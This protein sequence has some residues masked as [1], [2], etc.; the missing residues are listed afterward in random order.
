MR[1]IIVRDERALLN[2]NIRHDSVDTRVSQ[3]NSAARA[4]ALEKKRFGKNGVEERANARAAL[5]RRVD[6]KTADGGVRESAFTFSLSHFFSRR[7]L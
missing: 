1:R 3:G 7:T 2:I 5:L 4:R 6:P